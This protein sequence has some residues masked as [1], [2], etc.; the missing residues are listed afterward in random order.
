MRRIEGWWLP[1]LEAAEHSNLD[2][3]LEGG[4]QHHRE[5]ARGQ[6]L[7]QANGG[8]ARA[9]C[10]GTGTGSSGRLGLGSRGA[11]RRGGRRSGS[12]R[13]GGGGGCRSNGLGSGVAGSALLVLGAG[14]LALSVVRVVVDALAVGGL[15]DEEGKSLLVGSAV[16]HSAIG[17]DASVGEGGIVTLVLRS[18]TATDLRAGVQL[19][20]APVEGITRT[21]VRGVEG[22]G[23]RSG[24]DLRYRG[25][26][27][28]RGCA[29]GLNGLRLR[30]GKQSRGG[31][32]KGG[33]HDGG[34]GKRVRH[35]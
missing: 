15:T 12:S 26:G 31:E 14:S 2:H 3:E 9:R 21:D 22:C 13:R 1:E 33:Q 28:N 27:G 20:V 30:N 25:R 24:H 4:Q 29:G 5:S 18:R 19:G 11:G 7:R 8:I 23:R 32:D 17:T 35:E 10:R 34:V 6:L 16:G